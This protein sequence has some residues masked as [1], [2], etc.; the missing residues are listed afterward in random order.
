[1]RGQQVHLL[2]L[3]LGFLSALITLGAESEVHTDDRV[4]DVLDLQQ[5][6][7]LKREKADRGREGLAM[8]VSLHALLPLPS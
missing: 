7:R 6:R 8:G 4:C 2:G 3:A 5:E 1:M